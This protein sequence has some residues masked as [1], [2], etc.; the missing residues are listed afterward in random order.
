MAQVQLATST[1]VHHTIDVFC[2]DGDGGGDMESVVTSREQVVGHHDLGEVARA[3]HHGLSEVIE[4]DPATE[5][6]FTPGLQMERRRRVRTNVTFAKRSLVLRN[7]S[8]VPRSA[9]RTETTWAPGSGRW[10]RS[11]PC[12]PAA[13]TSWTRRRPTC[14][15]LNAMEKREKATVECDLVNK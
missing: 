6:H 14:P 12:A 11:P 3:Q 5:G 13:R 4:A 7:R 9:Y 15:S 10:P 2:W 8:A 1:I